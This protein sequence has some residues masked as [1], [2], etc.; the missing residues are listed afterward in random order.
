MILV[1]EPGLASAGARA[2]T[3]SGRLGSRARAACRRRGAR[4]CG[5]WL[6]APGSG[7]ARAPLLLPDG[8][9]NCSSC[10]ISAGHTTIRSSTHTHSSTDAMT[11][12][13]VVPNAARAQRHGVRSHRVI[14]TYQSC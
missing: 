14:E 5:P 12:I 13:C 8:I 6:P 10:F 7:L 3:C 9:P 2:N 4:S 11:L 1:W